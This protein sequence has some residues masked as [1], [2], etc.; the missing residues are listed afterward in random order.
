MKWDTV[1]L[2]VPRQHS[3]SIALGNNMS[4]DR[5]CPH[6]LFKSEVLATQTREHITYREAEDVVRDRF[7][8]D[9]KTYSFIT[10]KSETSIT[11]NVNP[12]IGTNKPAVKLTM[13]DLSNINLSTENPIPVKVPEGAEKGKFTKT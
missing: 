12:I 1:Q 11:T 2:S 13:G 8:E 3:V 7:R 5:K 10:K 6:Y 9:G 4:T